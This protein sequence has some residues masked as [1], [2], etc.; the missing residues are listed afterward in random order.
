MK[1][2]LYFGALVLMCVFAGSDIYLVIEN[3]NLSNQLNFEKALSGKYQAEME[4]LFFYYGGDTIYIPY[5]R[6]GY[7]DHW[8]AIKA[9]ILQRPSRMQVVVWREDSIIK[10]Q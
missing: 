3:K 10:N 6:G 5:K 8:E 2:I 1:K 4:N 9:G 7:T